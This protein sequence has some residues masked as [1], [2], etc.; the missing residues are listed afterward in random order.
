MGEPPLDGAA[1]PVALPLDEVG[2]IRGGVSTC[3]RGV[4]LR[5]ANFLW[6]C[7]YMRNHI[8]GFGENPLVAQCE[9]PTNFSADEVFSTNVE[10]H[11]IGFIFRGWVEQYNIQLLAVRIW[12]SGGGWFAPVRHRT[13]VTLFAYFY[14]FCHDG[15]HEIG[16]TF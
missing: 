13:G 1:A 6:C 14:S 9:H 5:D 12:Q 3:R 16:V 11:R 2:A 10:F 8:Q 4:I 7:D 15:H